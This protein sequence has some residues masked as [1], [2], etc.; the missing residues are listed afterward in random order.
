M[1]VSNITIKDRPIIR[2]ASLGA[3]V[4]HTPKTLLEIIDDNDNKTVV[5]SSNCVTVSTTEELEKY[6]GDPFIDPSVYS[7]LVLVYDLI[8]QGVSM[9]ISSVYDMQDNDD[10]FKK[11][12]YNGYTEFYFKDN[13]GLNA[14]GYKLKSDIKFCQPIIQHVELTNNS[15]QLHIYVQLYYLDRQRKKSLQ[16]L[17]RFDSSHL[18]K[19]IHFVYNTK[20]VVDEDI[21][22]DFYNNGLELQIVYGAGDNKAL[23]NELIKA[24]SPGSFKIVLRSLTDSDGV[25]DK[26]VTS[27]YEYYIHSSDYAYNFSDENTITNAYISA[28][29]AIHNAFPEPLMLCF[30]RM[31][32]A[33]NTYEQADILVGQQF[34][35]PS[36][37]LQ[38]GVFNYLLEKFNEDCNTY[39]FI[40]TPDLGVSSTLSALNQTDNYNDIISLP[41]HFNCDLFFGNA[42]DYIGNSLVDRNPRKAVYSAA[43]L[44]FYNLMITNAVYMTN[45]FLDLNISN[46]C[47][48]L[49]LSER[50]AEKLRDSRCNSI[51]LFDIGKP[52]VYGDRSLSL[53]P[54]LRYSHI[55]R[56]FVRLRRLIREYLETKKFIINTAYNIDSCISYIRTRILD[57]F[58]SNGVVSNY[59]IT[60]SVEY[61]TVNIKIILIFVSVVEKIE[62][63]FTI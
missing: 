40:N 57:E 17:N 43:L 19:I 35:Q 20:D 12:L 11:I 42:V 38:F 53:L 36:A 41:D 21:I 25:F 29:D 56:N 44:S 2:D 1:S 15:N 8:K 39:L 34:V 52:S 27:T 63:T 47:V 6:F 51:V 61:K 28:I 46:R 26:I 50:S 59:S 30:G 4:C 55:S 7:D 10:G 60:Y 32:S 31:F 45:N 16:D 54:N 13:N 48:K 62:L 24:A 33:K 3:I 37:D 58:V 5:T 14:I 22:N 49:V 18:Y 9:R 23:S